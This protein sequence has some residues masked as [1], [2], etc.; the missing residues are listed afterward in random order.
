MIL[1]EKDSLEITQ[2]NTIKHNDLHG[3]VFKYHTH[4][5]QHTTLGFHMSNFENNS[6][7]VDWQLSEKQTHGVD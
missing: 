4:N 1:T 7:I 2:K 6:F 3:L 5:N